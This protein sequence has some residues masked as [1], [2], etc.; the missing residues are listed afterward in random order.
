MGRKHESRELMFYL[1]NLQPNLMS[2]SPMIFNFSHYLIGFTI[3]TAIVPPP[4]QNTVPL[5]MFPSACG[6]L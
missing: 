2:L 3:N 6:R 5:S 4:G 1:R